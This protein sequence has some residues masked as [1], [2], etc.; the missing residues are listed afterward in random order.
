MGRYAQKSEK[1]MKLAVP[2]TKKLIFLENKLP[3]RLVGFLDE[4][5]FEQF[6]LNISKNWKKRLS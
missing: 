4:Q 3:Q 1:F 6:L 2:K 5:N